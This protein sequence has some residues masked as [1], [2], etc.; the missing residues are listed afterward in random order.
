MTFGNIGKGIVGSLWHLYGVPVAYCTHGECVCK[1]RLYEA[2]GIALLVSN[3]VFS[4]LGT[5]RR[6]QC[7]ILDHDGC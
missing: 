4:V 7:R 2:Y 5:Y 1:L 6:D 3:G